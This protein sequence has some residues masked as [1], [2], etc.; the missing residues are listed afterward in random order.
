MSFSSFISVSVLG[1]S[2]PT[3]PSHAII[4][5]RPGCRPCREIGILRRQRP[6]TL[7]QAASKPLCK[8]EL[9]PIV[10]IRHVHGTN[11]LRF[12]QSVVM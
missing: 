12:R 8:K 9:G 7:L 4:V 10:D 3:G 5:P 2:T 1:G 6:R 11:L